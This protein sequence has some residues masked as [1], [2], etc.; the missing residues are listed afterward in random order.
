MSRSI[1]CG[2]WM[3]LSILAVLGIAVAACGGDSAGGDGGDT[4]S[5]EG[6]ADGDALSCE[7]SDPPPIVAFVRPIDGAEVTG[8][9]TVEVSVTDRC[10]IRDVVLAVDGADSTTWTGEPYTW[11]WDTSGLV[12]GNHTITAR[13]TDAAGQ[14]ASATIEV[15]VRAECRAATDCPP[16]VHIVYPTAGSRVCGTLDVEATA[17]GEG[18]IADVTFRVD[19]A[20]LGAD[21]SAPYQVEWNT[22]G[23]ADGE[24]TLT[25]TAR[26]MVGQEARHAIGVETQNT[27]GTC[28]NLPTAVITDPADS[29]FVHGDVTVRVSASD[30]VGVVRVRMFV[31]AGMIWEDTSVPFDGVWHTDDFAEGPHV[32]RA[33]ATDTAGQQSAEAAIQVDVDRTPPTISI[34]APLDGETVSGTRVVVA[35]AADNLGVA[36]VAF[37]A[38]GGGMSR[39]FTDTEAPFEWSVD[40][41]AAAGCDGSVN[42]AADAADRAGWTAADSVSVTLRMPAE[43]CNGLDD[44][45]DGATDEDFACRPGTSRPCDTICGSLGTESCSVACAWEPTCYPPSEDCNGLDDDC[46]TVTD[47]GHACP[48]GRVE[49]CTTP[50]GDVGERRCS[51]GCA[52]GPCL[53]PNI[54]DPCTSDGDCTGPAATCLTA[55]GVVVLTGGYCTTGCGAGDDCGTANVCADTAPFGGPRTCLRGCT[56][57]TECRGTEGYRCTDW[58]VFTHGVC[59]PPRSDGDADGL[60]DDV[61]DCPT[62]W[63]PGQEDCDVDGVGDRCESGDSDGDGLADAIDLC[64]CGPTG[65]THDEDGDGLVDACDNCPL[66]ANPLQGNAN[67]DGLGD[68]CVPPTAPDLRLRI[69]RFEA[70]TLSPADPG[71]HVDG[72]T[73][74]FA[75]DTYTQGDSSATGVAFYAPWARGNDVFVQSVFDVTA[76]GGGASLTKRAGVV[77]RATAGTGM[78]SYYS[79][80]VEIAYDR[81]EIR[82]WDGV[83]YSVL[84]Q[85]DPGILLDLGWYRVSLLVQ[86]ANLACALEAPVGSPAVVTAVD[87]SL[88]SGGSGVM[89]AR[90]ASSFGGLMTAL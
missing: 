72:G 53:P 7:S 86:G 30:D 1:R 67:L 78:V 63:N 42:I 51:T 45:C 9:Q 81:L 15:D 87:A 2:N 82:K 74:S 35:D 29:S 60:P 11:S 49:P 84:G 47:N 34:T 75:G 17:T 70:F 69:D 76:V 77:A 83:A 28:D 20:L 4:S 19:D 89:T 48:L 41:P 59:L 40:F 6:D 38:T 55:V 66:V 85:V 5:P 33:E 80:S 23:L 56:L 13:A 71:W 24:H 65:G 46:D 61:D 21:D 22:N 64:P 68:A 52:W 27:G 88:V 12:S 8:V 73:W 25:A 43:T 62:V 10:G 37:T 44:D 14:T 79:C 57:D 90:S 58:M 50:L 32:L 54:G 16:R 39:S 3:L 36:S 26:D 31:D 18:D